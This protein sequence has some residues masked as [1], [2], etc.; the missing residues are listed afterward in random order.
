M[1][2]IKCCDSCG[3]SGTV[4]DEVDRTKNVLFFLSLCD[5]IVQNA[6]NYSSFSTLLLKIGERILLPKFDLLPFGL[7]F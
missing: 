5:L 1:T 6:S 4:I 2:A 3:L 7:M